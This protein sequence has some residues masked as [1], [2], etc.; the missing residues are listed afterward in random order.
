MKHSI[1]GK[2]D[3]GENSS[4]GRSKMGMA[5][6]LGMNLFAGVGIGLVAGYYVD[7]HFGCSPWGVLLGMLV[8]LGGGFYLMIKEAMQL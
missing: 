8:G 7:K 6:G 4:D 2:P 1:T 5:M 3:G